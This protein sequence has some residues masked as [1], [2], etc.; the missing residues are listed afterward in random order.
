M[1]IISF[2][3]IKH[4]VPNASSGTG[5]SEPDL[6]EVEC[7]NG[8]KK[9]IYID[10]WY[11]PVNGIYREFKNG[12]REKFTLISIDNLFEAYN[13]YLDEI[14]GTSCP[15]TKEEILKCY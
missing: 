6:F 12:I 10:I 1:K 2:K 3:K 15:Y 7:D 11:V 9:K 4:L 8:V 5:Y 13:M 14:V